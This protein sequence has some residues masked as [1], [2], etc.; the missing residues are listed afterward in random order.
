[1]IVKEILRKTKNSLTQQ[2]VMSRFLKMKNTTKQQREYLVEHCKKIFSSFVESVVENNF[3]RRMTQSHGIVWLSFHR[4][5]FVTTKKKKKNQKFN[6]TLSQLTCIKNFEK[7]ESY[8]SSRSRFRW[9]RTIDCRCCCNETKSTFFSLRISKSEA[10]FK[11][12]G[13]DVTIYTSQRWS[14]CFRET[15]I[16]IVV[17][18]FHAYRD[19]YSVEV[20]SF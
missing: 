18:F 6:S 4:F 12:T 20:I 2:E 10:P 8:F 1:M 13:N 16:C 3:W 17:N 14:H 19:R 5:S 11:K 15:K 9:C 7:C